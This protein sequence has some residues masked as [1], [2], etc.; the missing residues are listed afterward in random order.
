MSVFAHPIR[1]TYD[2][3]SYMGG[4]MSNSDQENFSGNKAWEPSKLEIALALELNTI[5][6]FRSQFKRLKTRFSNFSD[7]FRAA[8][9]DLSMFPRAGD[10]VKTR[11]LM[12]MEKIEIGREYEKIPDGVDIITYFDSRYPASLKEVYDPPPV[13]YVRGK[14]EYDYSS[15]ICIVGS[16]IFSDYGRQMAERFSYQLSSWGFTIISGGARGIDSIS[17]QACLN[18]G[19]N[20]FAVFGCG[21]DVVFPVENRKLFE[22]IAAAGALVSEFPIGTIPEK[23]NFPARNRIIAGLSRGA[24]VIEASE[25]SGA[26]ITIDMTSQLGREVFAVPGRLTDMGSRGT[27]FVI[28]DGGHLAIDPSDIPVRYGL[29]VIEGKP[30]EIRDPALI[31]KGDEAAVYECISLEAR[32]ADDIVHESGLNTSRVLSALLFLQTR[33]LVRELPGTRYVRPVSSALPPDM[34]SIYNDKRD[35]S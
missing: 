22:K 4:V 34:L 12:S 14:L 11:L 29:I 15:S 31:L 26:L 13:L 19:G 6:T 28:R 8:P 24:L 9:D 35:P 3:L 16:R 20:T 2:K 32:S 1:T 10:R 27:N 23:Y 21:I 30:D 17:H 33:G 25:K 18:A 7:I 5:P